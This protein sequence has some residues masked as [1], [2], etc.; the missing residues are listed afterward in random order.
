MVLISFLRTSKEKIYDVVM[1]E[2]C[3][4]V[5]KDLGHFHQTGPLHATILASNLLRG[6]SEEMCLSY[7]INGCPMQVT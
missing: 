1:N 6:P 3:I 4:L 7:L 2:G 5:S